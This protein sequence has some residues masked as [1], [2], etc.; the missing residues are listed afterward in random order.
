MKDKPIKETRSEQERLLDEA[1]AETFPAS[2]PISVQQVVI[3]G[4]VERP[5]RGGGGGGGGSGAKTSGAKTSGVKTSGVRP[6]HRQDVANR[7][8]IAGSGRISPA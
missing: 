6:K 5:L 3:V 8:G 1:L 4:Q 7:L 2:D